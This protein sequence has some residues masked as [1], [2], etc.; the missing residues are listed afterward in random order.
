MQSA[1]NQNAEKPRENTKPLRMRKRIG[2]TTF[3]VA[4]HFSQTSKETLGDK[5]IRLIKNEAM[6]Q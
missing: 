6:N 2:S 5:I 3:D 4:V 1:T